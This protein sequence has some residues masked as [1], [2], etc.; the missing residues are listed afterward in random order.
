MCARI[1]LMK[2]VV[3]YIHNICDKVFTGMNILSVKMF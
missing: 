3:V 1:Y 2:Q